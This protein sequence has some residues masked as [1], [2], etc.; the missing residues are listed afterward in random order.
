MAE[1]TIK[2][3]A[4]GYQRL[5]SILKKQQK[6]KLYILMIAVLSAIFTSC[7]NGTN[8]QASDEQ[9]E[10]HREAPEGVVVLNKQQRKVLALELGTF[11]MRNLTT[12]VKT[13]GQLEVPPAASADVST[14]IGGN[15]KEIKVFDGD[16]VQQGQVLAL[17]EHPDYI[18]IQEDF[19]KSANRLQFLELEYN[20]QKELFDNKVGSGK[21]FQQIQS[22]FNT[23]KAK[24]EGL[25]ARLN[26]LHISVDDAKNGI[27][28]STSPI[29]S[30]IS[31]YVNDVKIK[32]GTYVNAEDKLFNITDNR[33]V[34]ADFLVYEKDAGLLKLGQ[35]I[36][37]TV[38]NQQGELSAKIFAIG[39][40]FEPNVRAVHIHAQLDSVPQGL[41]P[42]MY[43]SGHIHT[44][45]SYVQTL[46][47]D[48]IVSEGTQSYIFVLD[49][50]LA[51]PHAP[52]AQTFKMVE[53][54]VGKEDEGY[55][56]VK[57]L[58]PLPDDTQIV[59]NAAYYLM[60][61][62]KKEETE[63]ED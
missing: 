54:V 3:I 28:V 59:L 38:A 37:F 56:E 42:G 19:A 25:K 5:I 2:Q 30:P 33:R 61:D 16:K 6:M 60:A 7:G 10:T 45:D 53:V 26:L 18:T 27:I 1:L 36:D 44:N 20:R 34:H 9:H 4:I 50:E 15:V 48:A 8:K 14:I 22:D 21:D 13:N 57:L 29:V 55:T 35:K 31:G 62:L 12:V 43:V 32:L 17:L 40:K 46:P 58:T 39:K 23:E 52:D 63:H 24:F 51:T 47:N 11:K 41:I 49:K